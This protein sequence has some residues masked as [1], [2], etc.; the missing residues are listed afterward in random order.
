MLNFFPAGED[1]A[2]NNPFVKPQP[3]P[4]YSSATSAAASFL[5]R[6]TH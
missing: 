2:E 5:S 6:K 3:A 4:L 1:V